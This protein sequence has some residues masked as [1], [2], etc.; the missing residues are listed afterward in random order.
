VFLFLRGNHRGEPESTTINTVGYPAQGPLS[1]TF[2]H[3]LDQR[4]ASFFP[5]NSE[6]RMDDRWTTVRNPARYMGIYRG[7]TF[8]Y[9]IVA[10]LTP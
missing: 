7:L 5:H 9:P 3:I 1:R 10:H 8:V 6:D 4:C 2:L